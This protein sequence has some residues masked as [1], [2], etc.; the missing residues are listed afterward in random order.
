MKQR[1][2]C[3]ANRQLDIMKG[4]VHLLYNPILI[5]I[6]LSKFIFFLRNI[7]NYIYTQVHVE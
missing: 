4:H 6:Y 2:I 3:I 7:I 1:T 5:Y